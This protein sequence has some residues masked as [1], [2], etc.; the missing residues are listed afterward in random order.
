[1]YYIIPLSGDPDIGRK[2]APLIGGKI[3]NIYTKEH[4]DGEQYIRLGDSVSGKRVLI[5]QSMFPEQD[6]KYIELLLAIDAAI[7]AGASRV[8]V[9]VSYL[10]Y[11]RQDKV[12]LDTISMALTHL[13]SWDLLG[14]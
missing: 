11:A 14:S 4:P 12:F 2:L 1:M 7:R 5:V 8:D 3:V 10:A 6:R 9:L 13:R